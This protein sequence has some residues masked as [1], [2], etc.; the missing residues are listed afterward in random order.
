MARDVAHGPTEVQ[1]VTEYRE[2][3]VH[4]D[5][6]GHQYGV[7]RR[8]GYKWVDRYDAAG[9]VGLLNHSRRPHQSPCAT[10]AAIV[11]ALVAARNGHRRWGARKLLAV[12][13]R[14]EPAA[15][16]RVDRPRR[17]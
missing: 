11:A 12:L 7:G 4:D 15:H 9:V 8:T 3:V 13:A 14:R 6:T 16:G 2:R 5:R 1:F 10:D 17:S